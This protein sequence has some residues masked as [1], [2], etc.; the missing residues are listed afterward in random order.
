M[1]TGLSSYERTPIWGA[2]ANSIL[3]AGNKLFDDYTVN[4]QTIS[5]TQY[6]SEWLYDDYIAPY[7]NGQKKMFYDTSTDFSGDAGYDFI[8]PNI[9]QQLAQGYGF[10]HVETHGNPENWQTEGNN[11]NVLHATELENPGETILLTSAC[12]TNAFDSV[13]TCLSE[14]FMRNKY[15][16]FLAYVGCSRSGWAST[17]ISM[18]GASNHINGEI[19][20][21][22]FTNPGG[23]FGEAFARGKNM[24]V[25]E[26]QSYYS[27]YRWLLL[28][29]NALG[30]PEMPVFTSAPASFTQVRID[31]CGTDFTVMTNED[32]CTIC[33][34]QIGGTMYLPIVNSNYLYEYQ[35]LNGVYNVCVSKPGYRPY[36]RR[37]SIGEDMVLQNETFLYDQDVTG[38]NI[39]IGEGINPDEE[40]GDVIVKS[41]KLRL[42]RRNEI[43]I[44]DSFEVSQGAEFEI[45]PFGNN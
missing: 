15:S 25:G 36:N 17:G 10:V 42:L 13:S 40:L 33:M 3:M 1:S 5:D 24:I 35:L 39:I 34:T 21:K 28:G 45:V 23:S 9:N 32:S 14:G 27:P 2:N 19:F 30:D 26:C 18:Q 11:Y 44:M 31:T 16:G 12:L 20:K 29:V 41:G 37:I 38:Q 4:G 43:N 8:P 22:I 6:K 7:W